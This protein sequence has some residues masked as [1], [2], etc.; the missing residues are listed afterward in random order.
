[1]TN[2]ERQRNPRGSGYLLRQDLLDAAAS[3]LE[4]SG[5]EDAV[6][7][8]AVARRAG[9]TPASVYAHFDGVGVLLTSVI[10]QA[11]D[12]LTQELQRASTAG[13]TADERF[14]MVCDAYVAFARD[15]PGRYRVMFSRSG[16]ERSK[17]TSARREFED[18]GG[19][20]ALGVLVSVCEA[21][22]ENESDPQDPF[23]EAIT[24]WVAL[25]GYATLSSAVPAFPW[26][27][28]LLATLLDRVVGAGGQAVRALTPGHFATSWVP[29]D[30]EEEGQ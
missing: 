22:S 19:A 29:I 3:I 9:V 4:E 30:L 14:V 5:N 16:M 17:Q 28:N 10:A 11:F 27:T 2:A 26:P 7:L 13:R 18:L 23:T 20:E 1:M 6:T 8:R 21:L 25:H 24:V 15:H 12:A